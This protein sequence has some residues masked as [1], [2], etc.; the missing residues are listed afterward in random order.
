MRQQ[1]ALHRLYSHVPC[2]S[3]RNVRSSCSTR[4]WGG[5]DEV[6]SNGV[7]D[8]RKFFETRFIDRLMPHITLLFNGLENRSFVLLDGSKIM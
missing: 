3:R 5:E 1:M 6:L 7:E 4:Y 2:L 8:L